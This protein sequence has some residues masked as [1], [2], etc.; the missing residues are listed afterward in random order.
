MKVITKIDNTK[1]GE[2]EQA[3]EYKDKVKELVKTFKS[4]T[5]EMKTEGIY[6]SKIYQQFENIIKAE[7]DG[8]RLSKI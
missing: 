6:G 3:K 7:G 5:K 1:Q 8:K 2:P 4:I